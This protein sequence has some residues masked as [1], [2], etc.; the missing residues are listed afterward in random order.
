MP[1]T[2]IEFNAPWGSALKTTSIFGT[3]ILVILI[4]IGIDQVD[5]GRTWGVFLVALPAIVLLLSIACVVRGYSLTEREILVNRLGWSTHL[6]L[7]NLQSV[8]GKA[9]VTKSALRLFGN[10]GV[11]S[12]TGFYWN[13]EL[14]LFRAFV[15]D[16]SRAVVLRYPKI[17]VVI[18][19][20]DPQ[21]FIM[22]AR[23]YLK[24]LNLPL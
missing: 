15:T 16:P 8:E 10:A 19:P 5:T 14:R 1:M 7:S 2:P 6:S 17:A 20:H 4:A 21:Q 3:A 12:F 11:F 24:T 22:R 23:T 18:T 9:D 13:R